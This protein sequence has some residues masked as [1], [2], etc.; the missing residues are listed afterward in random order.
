MLSILV[1]HSYYL[2]LDQKQVLRA[3]P[4]PPLATLQVVAL[5]RQAGYRVSFFDAPCRLRNDGICT[6]R[7][8]QSHRGTAACLKAGELRMVRRTNCDSRKRWQWTP[9]E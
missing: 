9:G 5:L 6:A 3:K 2:L 4:Y 7:R 1:C 8:R